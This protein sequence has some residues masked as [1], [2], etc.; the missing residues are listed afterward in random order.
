MRPTERKVEQVEREM[1]KGT[2]EKKLL[3][4][5]NAQIQPYLKLTT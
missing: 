3:M 5:C 4:T 1:G 2:N